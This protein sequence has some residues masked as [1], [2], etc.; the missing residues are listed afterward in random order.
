MNVEPPI[1]ALVL[2]ALVVCFA[3]SAASRSRRGFLIGCAPFIKGVSTDGPRLREMGRR[4]VYL[5]GLDDLLPCG[6]HSMQWR[7]IIR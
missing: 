6:K 7:F 2:P 1:T 3:I 4:D 5:P